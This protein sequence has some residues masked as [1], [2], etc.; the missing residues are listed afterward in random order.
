MCWSQNLFMCQTEWW[1]FSICAEGWWQVSTMLLC[2]DQVLLWLYIFSTWPSLKTWLMK[3]FFNFNY[4]YMFLTKQIFYIPIIHCNVNDW[5]FIFLSYV[6]IDYVNVKIIHIVL[7][8][9]EK[10]P[11]LFMDIMKPYGLFLVLASTFFDCQLTH[12]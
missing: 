12:F 5:C 3:Y 8:M 1:W 7:T 10:C 6:S 4:W 2:F 11:K 9:Q